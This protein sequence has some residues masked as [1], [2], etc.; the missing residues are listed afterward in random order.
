MNQIDFTHYK[1]TEYWLPCT[2]SLIIYAY[3]SY[4]KVANVMFLK[5][6]DS[7]TFDY[8]KITFIDFWCKSF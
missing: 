1:L 2:E 8:S 6:C 4:M 5:P 7:K 3:N